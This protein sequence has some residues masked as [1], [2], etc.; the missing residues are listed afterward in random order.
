MA[1]LSGKQG[2]FEWAAG[3]VANFDEWSVSVDVNMLDV[4]TFSTGT[5]QWRDMIPGLSGFTGTASGNFDVDSTGLDDLRVATLTPATGTAKFEMDK[6][7]G[8]HFTGGVYVQ[9][10]GHTAPIDGVVEVD[11]SFQGTGALTY[12]TT[13]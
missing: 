2:N 9:T 8:E 1:E 10:M 3:H 11:F 12:T 5:L 4:T 13:T 7:G 6:D